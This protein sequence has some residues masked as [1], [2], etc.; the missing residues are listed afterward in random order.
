M[1]AAT[2]Y[3]NNMTFVQWKDV[4]LKYIDLNIMNI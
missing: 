1:E 3:W 2:E 4:N